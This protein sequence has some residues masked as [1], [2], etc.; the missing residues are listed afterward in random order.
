IADEPTTALDVTIQAQ[1]LALLRELQRET[2][3]AI[4]LITHNFGV[5]AEMADRVLV[6]YA[7][8][9]VESG[10]VAAMLARPAHPYTRGLLA[11]SP[12][13]RPPGA[14]RTELAEIPGT[15]PAP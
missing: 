13:P 10:P 9:I 15:V 6:M 11:A 14:A 8:R 2:G 4:L 3:I 12:R 5:V 7:G 1:I